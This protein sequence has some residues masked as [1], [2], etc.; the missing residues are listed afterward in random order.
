MDQEKLDRLRR[1]YAGITREDY[2][3]VRYLSLDSDMYREVFRAKKYLLDSTPSGRMLDLGT[4]PGYFPFVCK[5]YG[6]DAIGVDIE[7]PL[8]A[9]LADIIETDRFVWPVTPQLAAPPFE[10][11]FNTVTAF[12]VAF[13]NIVNR[14]D[15]APWSTADWRLFFCNLIDRFVAEDGR[16]FMTGVRAC[17]PSTAYYD[18]ELVAFLKSINA[19]VVNGKITLIIDRQVRERLA[20]EITRL[21][22]PS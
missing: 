20:G 19:K 8:F 2:A 15:P 21:N 7:E 12:Q 17:T 4:G 13:D 22:E 16:I 10:G 3:W 14:T 6:H 5:Q 9:R 1:E 18:E 11:R